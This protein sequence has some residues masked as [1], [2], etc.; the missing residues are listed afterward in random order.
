MPKMNAKKKSRARKAEPQ[1]AMQSIGATV[2]ELMHRL[3]HTAVTYTAVVVVGGVLV[4]MVMLLAGGYFSNVGERLAGGSVSVAKASGFRIERVTLKG[5]RHTSA[6][7]ILA[8]LSDP[9]TGPATGKSLLHFGLEEART[10]I[11]KLGWVEHASVTRLWPDTLHVSV[12]ERTPAAVWQTDEKGSLFLVDGLGKVIT[13][14]SGDEYASLPMIVGAP[15]TQKAEH[16]VT[17]LS[18]YP[19]LMSHLAALKFKGERRWDIVFSNGFTVK[20]P[21]ENPE[22]AI[23]RIAKLYKANSDMIRRLEYLDLRDSKTA[24]LLPK[25][26]KELED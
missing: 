26:E 18:R 10:R 11:E 8:M 16:I 4:V 6:A 20:L 2:D 13:R 15:S 5:A 12:S 22:L 25:L 24:T 23:A 17:A 3:V 1:G 14:V 9:K 21:E 19:S 7:E